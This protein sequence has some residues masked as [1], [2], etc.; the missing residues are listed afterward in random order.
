[1]QLTKIALKKQ[2]LINLLQKWLY[3]ILMDQLKKKLKMKLKVT[4]FKGEF[5]IK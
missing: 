4:K 1:M 2:C 5:K 3:L